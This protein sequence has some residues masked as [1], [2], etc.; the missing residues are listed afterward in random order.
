ME[1]NPQ[2]VRNCYNGYRAHSSLDGETP[3]HVRSDRLITPAALHHLSGKRAVGDYFKHRWQRKFEFAAHLANRL[4]SMLCQHLA[5]LRLDHEPTQWRDRYQ[6]I[7][8][9]HINVRIYIL[10]VRQV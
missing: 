5:T 8:A 10:A 2:K 9:A 7:L 6:R 3:E 4:I 1:R